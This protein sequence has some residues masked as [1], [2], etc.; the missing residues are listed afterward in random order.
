MRTATG[1]GVGDGVG[2]REAVLVA[3]GVFVIVGVEV[4]VLVGQVPGHG[5]GVAEGVGVG[6]AVGVR[7]GVG[8]GGVSMDTPPCWTEPTVML[9]PWGRTSSLLAMT[10]GEKPALMAVSLTVASSPVPSG[11]GGVAPSVTQ[12]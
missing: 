11:P 5:V 3:L 2:V 7:L 12:A 9:N 10:S 6:V 1:P 4:G 8:V